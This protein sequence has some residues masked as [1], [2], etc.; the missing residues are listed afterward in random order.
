MYSINSFTSNVFKGL[1]ENHVNDIQ[2]PIVT[3]IVK[4]KSKNNANVKSQAENYHN[5]MRIVNSVGVTCVES[6]NK[7]VF[8]SVLFVLKHR[9]DIPQNK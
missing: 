7:E 6:L 5:K 4:I 8:L 1:Y 2:C 3:K 9:T